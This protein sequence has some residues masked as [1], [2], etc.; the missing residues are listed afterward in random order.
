MISKEDI[1][2]VREASDI[3]SLFSERTQVKQRGHDFWCCCPFHNEK[4]PSCKIDPAGQLWHC[5][6]CGEGGDIFAYLMKIE[7]AT[8]V[9]AVKSLADR[10]HISLS[11]TSSEKKQ[12]SKK[13]RLQDL[14]SKTMEFYHNELM[15][16]AGPK[17][18]E[19]RSYLS[20]RNLGGTV[21]TTW[22][23][24]F[25]PGSNKL[26]YH[27]RSLG[28]SDQEMIDANVAHRRNNGMLA[29]RFFN[30]IMFPIQDLSGQC[31]AFGGRVIGAGEPKYLNSK[32]TPLFHKSD[33]L[34]GLHKAKKHISEKGVALVVEGYTDVIALHEHGFNNAVATLGTALTR[35]HIRLLSR[36]ASDKIIYLFDGD[37]A[38][39]R[40]AE[41][42]LQFID[43]SIAPESATTTIDLCAI[44][45]PDNADPADYLSQNQE[46][47]LKKLIDEAEPLLSFG[48]KKRLAKYDI[49][50]F[51]GRGKAL[52]DALN[53]LVPIR[54]SI[55]AKE[56]ARTIAGML[57]VDENDA[58]QTLMNLKM[59]MQPASLRNEATDVSSQRHGQMDNAQRHVAQ[60]P[61]MRNRMLCEKHFLCY[62]Y[63]Y[64]E[65]AH[66]YLTP[67]STIQ[68]KSGFNRILAEHLLTCLEKEEN[69]TPAEL[70]SSLYKV[71][72]RAPSYI[73]SLRETSD[74]NVKST[75]HY[76]VSELV[77]SDLEHDL[78]QIQIELK[79]HSA[80]DEEREMMFTLAVDLQNRISSLKKEHNQSSG[81]S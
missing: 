32:E 24:G 7:G 42:A 23:L 36:F 34:Y 4:T 11:F 69:V 6:G 18:D 17:H 61:K 67:L 46:E 8:F 25:T 26:I 10:A 27:L 56:Y 51:E 65:L 20:S 79:N 48:I 50:S 76:L 39:Q 68:W 71:D 2:R 52:I 5:F 64:P 80:Q 14:C 77:I 16:V 70:V 28:Y 47:Q 22:N 30:R 81:I 9:E 55:L 38:G 40:A 63:R 57:Q 78:H 60:T 49:S 41:R 43:E 21:P 3:V 66:E 72:N 12:F 31:I 62:L 19:A 15:K 75:I 13:V 44:T 37:A 33:V 1:Q 59:P 29:D 35:Q 74:N 53:V 45:L 58:L 54:D 73:T